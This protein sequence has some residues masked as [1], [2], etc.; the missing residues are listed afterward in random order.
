VISALS[1]LAES[2]SR[3]LVSYWITRQQTIEKRC[4]GLETISAALW[5][6]LAP[7]MGT[8]AT[9]AI[10]SRAVTLASRQNARL[11]TIRVVDGGLDVSQLCLAVV[12]LDP[13][14]ASE[15]L[16]VV[17]DELMLV[18]YRLLGGVLVPVLNEVEAELARLLPARGEDAN[19]E[20]G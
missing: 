13:E 8:V 15:N 18:L 17:V 9:R 5:A 2:I 7:M 10:F 6:V 12:Q 19:E 20:G 14:V 3:R 1:P 4:G 16:S 11:G